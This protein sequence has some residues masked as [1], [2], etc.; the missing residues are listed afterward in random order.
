VLAK[1]HRAIDQLELLLVVSPPLARPIGQSVHVVLR[2][3]HFRQ[4]SHLETRIDTVGH[5]NGVTITTLSR[6]GSGQQKTP[7]RRGSGQAF[8][9]PQGSPKTGEDV[10][11][12]GGQG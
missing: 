12:W 10:W 7:E 9:S 8:A 4:A 6:R 3:E 1:A 2:G 5:P 11:V